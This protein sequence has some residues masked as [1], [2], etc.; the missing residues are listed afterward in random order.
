MAEQTREHI[1]KLNI[2]LNLYDTTIAVNIN[3]DDE[4]NLRKAE[5]LINETINTYAAIYKGKRDI[6]EILLMAMIEIASRYVNE[7]E[8]NDTAPFN[9]FLSRL[10]SEVEDALS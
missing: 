4:E 2:R 3:R 5:R 1:D 10:T 9:E 6:K 8:R 7:A